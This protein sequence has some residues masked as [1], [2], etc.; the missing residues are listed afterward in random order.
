M[1]ENLEALKERVVQI[2]RRFGD[3]DDNETQ[4]ILYKLQAISNEVKRMLRDGTACS[5]TFWRL[6]ETHGESSSVNL[7]CDE[8]TV[9]LTCLDSFREI[10]R[11]LQE[12]ELWY[13]DESLDHVI[14]CG[15][16]DSSLTG[17]AGAGRVQVSQLPQQFS[18]VSRLVVGTMA[19][20]HRFVEFNARSNDFWNNTQKR[21]RSLE[22]EWQALEESRTV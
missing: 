22:R 5:K 13:R 10:L 9:L 3:V 11:Q 21:V 6:L 19:L 16:L 2:E 20:M 4:T 14:S 15:I 17:K 18:Q 7:S 12:L 1:R 8:K